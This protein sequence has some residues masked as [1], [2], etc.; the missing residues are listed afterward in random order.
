MRRPLPLPLPL[1]AALL[2][3]GAGAGVV[4]GCG[5]SDPAVITIQGQVG[6]GPAP[7]ATPPV[8]RAFQVPPGVPRASDGQPA[9]AVSRRVIR[10][11]LSAL[12]QGDVARAAR[13]F[14]LPSKV[15]N[16]TPVVTL[17][18]PRARVAFNENLPCGA[19][20]TRL[21]HAGHGFTVVEFVL[22]QRV[23]ADCGS[24]TGNTA[25]SAIRVA[26]G[27]IVEWYR[28]DDLTVP[29]PGPG[30]LDPGAKIA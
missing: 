29:V 3:V 21:E 5:G 15:Q 26:R 27:H 18:S 4:A 6:G 24:G 13:F 14:A 23:G 25:R 10:K 8:P 30:S 2:A 22:T 11:W 19:R 7:G 16:G 1:L 12:R 9:D 28:L 20:A 17:R